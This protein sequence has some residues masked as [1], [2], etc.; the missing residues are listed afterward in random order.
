MPFDRSPSAERSEGSLVPAK[1]LTK[2]SVAVTKMSVAVSI[3]PTPR[4]TSVLAAQAAPVGAPS[5]DV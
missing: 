2:M 3:R 1:K 5:V 4:T